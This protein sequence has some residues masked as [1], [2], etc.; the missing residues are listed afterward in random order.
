MCLVFITLRKKY[1]VCNNNKLCTY[2]FF[3]YFLKAEFQIWVLLN[4]SNNLI[5]NKSEWCNIANRLLVLVSIHWKVSDGLPLKRYAKSLTLSWTKK[6][7]IC[8]R[9]ILLFYCRC[10][11][12]LPILNHTITLFF[13]CQSIY[14]SFLWNSWW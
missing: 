3:M 10:H 6:K 13:L 4:Y 8:F 9:N 12:F 5:T 2:V 14:L 11:T 1:Y 7:I